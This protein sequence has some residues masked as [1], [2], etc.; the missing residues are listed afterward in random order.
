M[1][2]P[3]LASRFA[4]LCLGAALSACLGCS[5]ASKPPQDT[6]EVDF[7]QATGI[8][9]RELEGFLDG[10]A[11]RGDGPACLVQLTLQ[12][13]AGDYLAD[14]RINVRW[15]VGEYRLLVGKSAV[16]QFLLD[17]QKLPGLHLI[18]PRGF[19][20]LKQ[21][22]IPLGSSYAP[23]DPS[24]L[25]SWGDTLIWDGR[26]SGELE[27]GLQRLR[28]SGEAL[29]DQQVRDQL[30]R[31]RHPL[32]LPEPP[33]AQLSPAEVYQ[34]R[35]DAV[36][37]FG[38]LMADGSLAVA[39][40]VVVHPSGVVATAYHVVAKQSP[41]VARAVLTRTGHVF[42]VREILAADRSG[43]VV[44]VKIDAHDLSAAPVSSGDPVGEPVTIIAHP[45]SNFFTLTHGHIS[46]YWAST[47]YGE[48]TACMSVTAEFA[49][50]SSGGPIF[51]SHGAV[52]GLVS[53][54]DP[55]GY[56]MVRRTAVPAATI[57]RLLAQPS[58]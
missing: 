54:T 42:A 32:V 45:A 29:S 41:V 44:L 20:R 11:A 43:D 48:L 12:N 4:V 7:Y 58:D 39:S 16:V 22:T 53:A 35:R 57:R 15:D 5:R 10:L 36:V 1:T 30:R 56:Q 25:A 33:V 13:D 38:T 52:A 9:Q 3:A 55:F 27:R 26:I 37:V 31:K 28:A 49:E 34:H 17:K 46:R 21:R 19:T 23:E 47:S 24:Q 8:T 2:E 51:N 50:G 40:G 6:S 14:S 18:V